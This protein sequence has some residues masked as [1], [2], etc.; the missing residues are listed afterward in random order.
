M[1]SPTCSAPSSTPTPAPRASPTAP[2]W[3]SHR[4]WPARRASGSTS[5]SP[6]P[7]GRTASRGARRTVATR[8]PQDETGR[9]WDVLT[10]TRFGIRR[11][12]GGHRAAIELDRVPRDGKAQHAVRTQLVAHIGPGDH[13]EPVMTIMQPNED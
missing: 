13:A 1:T 5:P 12:P 10:T 8:P 7:P 6:P 9:L 3:K 4:T 11:S 2:W